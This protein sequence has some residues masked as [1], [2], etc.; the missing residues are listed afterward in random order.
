LD[1][2]VVAAVRVESVFDVDEDGEVLSSSKFEIDTQGVELEDPSKSE[3]ASKQFSGSPTES[4]GQ[5]TPRPRGGF[6][7]SK[8]SNSI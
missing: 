4:P 2:V 5:A 8:V 1:V 7:K 6:E 3:G